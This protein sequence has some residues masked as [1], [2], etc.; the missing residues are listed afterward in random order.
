[1]QSPVFG[2]VGE[3]LMDVC[4]WGALTTLYRGRTWNHLA[5]NNVLELS[6]RSEE[7]GCRE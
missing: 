4:A 6:V 1:M 5:G 3:M 7:E 2:I